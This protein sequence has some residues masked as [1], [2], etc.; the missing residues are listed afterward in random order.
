ML[1]GLVAV[2]HY[3]GLSVNVA[4]LAASEGQGQGCLSQGPGKVDFDCGEKAQTKN[5]VHHVLRKPQAVAVLSV[6]EIILTYF[7]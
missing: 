1:H 6:K 3:P 5:T 4:V 7:G 2:D